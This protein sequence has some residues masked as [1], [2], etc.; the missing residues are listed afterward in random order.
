MHIA[1]LLWCLLQDIKSEIKSEPEAYSEVA[2]NGDQAKKE[3]F[4]MESVKVW[5]SV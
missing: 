4:K 5:L 1:W 3:M 2:E